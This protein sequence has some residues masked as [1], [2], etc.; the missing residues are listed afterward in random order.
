LCGTVLVI[1]RRLVTAAFCLTLAETTSCGLCDDGA[2]FVGI[3]PFNIALFVGDK[4][5][6]VAASGSTDSFCGGTDPN[7]ATDPSAYFFTVGDPTIITITSQGDITAV[8]AGTTSIGATRGNLTNASAAQ[9][10][11]ARPIARLEF[12][13][14]PASP[15]VGDTVTVVTNAIDQQ[16]AITPGAFFSGL[17]L[18]SAPVAGGTNATQVVPFLR[19]RMRFVINSAGRYTVRNSAM[20]QG[21]VA[22]SAELAINVP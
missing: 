5:K 3:E 15:Q 21:N 17:Q 10:Y 9:V 8:S 14:T 22:A 13:V 2:D 7:S 4:T 6:V 20:R 1:S 11:V 16:G 18:Q 19:E 12:A